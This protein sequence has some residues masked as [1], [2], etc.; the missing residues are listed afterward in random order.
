LVKPNTFRK[1]IAKVKSLFRKKA[2]KTFRKKA[3][4]SLFRK[5]AT[6]SL[7][8]KKA[9]KTFRKAFLE[10]KNTAKTFSNFFFLFCF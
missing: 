3:A 2:T 10:K 8:R 4:K 5:K 7:F 6:K 9:A 1:S